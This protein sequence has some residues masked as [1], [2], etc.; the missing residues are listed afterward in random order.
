M[1]ITSADEA[2]IHAVLP[3]STAAGVDAARDKVVVT[4]TAPFETR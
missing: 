3:A 1:N 2:R 4:D